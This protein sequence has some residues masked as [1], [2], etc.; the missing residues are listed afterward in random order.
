MIEM[1]EK[2]IEQIAHGLEMREQ[3]IEQIARELVL[4]NDRYMWD[5]P[6]TGIYAELNKRWKNSWRDK[7]RR[8]LE[9][10]EEAKR[11]GHI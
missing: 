3:L 4:L 2:I 6:M 9:L 1:R 7:A 11:N 5:K 10:V 8:V